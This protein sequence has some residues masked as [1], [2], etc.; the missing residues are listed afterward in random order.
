MTKD[1]LNEN[2]R[3]GENGQGTMN[4]ITKTKKSKRTRKRKTKKKNE[5]KQKQRQTHDNSPTQRRDL[6]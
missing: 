5:Q 1:C 3:P 2:T 4:I 6:S